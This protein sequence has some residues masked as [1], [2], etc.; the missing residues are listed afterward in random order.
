MLA[1]AGGRGGT[2]Q[3]VDVVIGGKGRPV[4]GRIALKAPPG[5]HVNWRR[6]RPATVEKAKA[7]NQFQG[8]LGP[9]PRQNDRFAASL[10]KDGRFR[11]EDVPAGQYDL[12]VTIDAPPALGRPGP[13]EEL[14]RVKV[15]LVVPEGDD[16]DAVNLG[17]I[18]AEVKGR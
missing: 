15:L 13:V 17:E 16:G 9:D 1:G 5:V 18:A 2:G 11:V 3:T 8:R 14:G 4:I 10:D 6:N 12:T 7:F